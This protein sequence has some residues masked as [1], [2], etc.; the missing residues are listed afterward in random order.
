MKKG[1]LIK[2]KAKENAARYI[3]NKFCYLMKEE[4]EFTKIYIEEQIL[5]WEHDL[6]F[7]IA[8]FEDLYQKEMKRRNIFYEPPVKQYVS[9]FDSSACARALKHKDV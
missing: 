9:R 7:A 8:C 6:D 5:A 3:I 4:P 2:S 1:K